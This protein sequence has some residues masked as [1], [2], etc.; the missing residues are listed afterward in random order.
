M[1]RFIQIVLFIFGFQF[2]TL[3]QTQGISYTAVGKG[4]ATTFV[5]D[6][7]CL[8]INASALGW[9]TGYE[10]KRF[11]MGLTEFGAGIYSDNMSVDKLKKVYRSIQNGFANSSSFSLEDRENQSNAILDFGN[12]GVSIFANYNWLGFAFQSE[13]FGGL[14]FNVSE[15]IKWYSKL[16]D[17]TKDLVFRGNLSGLFDSLQIVIAGDTSMIEYDPSMT[18][19]P[20]T[21]ASV[22]QGTLNV[23]LPFSQLTK[24]SEIRAS[25]NRNYNIGYGRKI[26]GNDSVFAIYGGIGARYIQSVAMFNMVSD[27]NGLFMYSSISPNFNIDYGNVAANNPSATDQKGSLLPKVVGNG[28]GIDLAASVVMFGKLKIAAAVNNIGSVTYNRNVYKVNDTVSLRNVSIDGFADYNITTAVKQMLNQGGLF[29]LQ[30]QEK[31]VIKNGADF[32]FGASFQ[33]G[34]IAHVGID[35]VAPFDRT[36]P[37]SIVNPVYSIGGEIRPFKWVAISAGYFGGGVYKNNIPVGINFIVKDGA[38]E[39]GISSYDALSFFTKKSNSISAA[40]GVARMRF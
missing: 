31:Y 40:F 24:G 3:S 25:W 39:I 6:Y 8:G 19:S 37:S 13:K 34:K 10:G 26:V 23:A 33:F 9:G 29:T 32:R 1:K 11:T 20:D 4:V 18:Y 36:A 17:D 21:L 14:A 35:V 15:N 22:I 30:G 5:T 7:H 27:D 16:S 28:Y 12:S 38:Y 2:L